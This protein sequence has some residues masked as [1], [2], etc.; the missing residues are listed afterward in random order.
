ME[1]ASYKMHDHHHL[2]RRAWQVKDAQK[3]K[4]IKDWSRSLGVCKKCNEENCK[5]DGL[6]L[7]ERYI[8]KEDIGRGGWALKTI[9]LAW[10][11][12]ESWSVDEATIF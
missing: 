6:S 7:K 4:Q 3:L 5:K 8:N 9:E 11:S 2:N 12:M 1:A 10:S